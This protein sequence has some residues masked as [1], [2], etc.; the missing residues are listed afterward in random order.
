MSWIPGSYDLS[1]GYRKITNLY[2]GK[3]GSTELGWMSEWDM[4]KGPSTE[5]GVYGPIYA[6]DPKYLWYL[7]QPEKTKKAKVHTWAAQHKV[8]LVAM[9]VIIALL[10]GFIIFALWKHFRGQPKVSTFEIPET[11]GLSLK[12]ASGQDYWDV[13]SGGAMTY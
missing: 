11:S 13:T 6:R 10:F 8:F 1:T 5:Q 12:T 9:I 3:R 7:D 4:D 2:G